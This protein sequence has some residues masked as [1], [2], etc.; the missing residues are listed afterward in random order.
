MYAGAISIHLWK[1]KFLTQ[2]EEGYT[3]KLFE[4]GDPYLQEHLSINTYLFVRIILI[5]W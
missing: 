3:A 5:I 1:K 2:M 4:R